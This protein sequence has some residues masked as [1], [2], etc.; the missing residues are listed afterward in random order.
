MTARAVWIG[1]LMLLP[2]QL[3]AQMTKPEVFGHIGVF[4]AGSDDGRIGSAA[5]FGGV[6]VIPVARRFAADV[7][8]QTARVER[9]RTADS[10]YITRRTL[11]VP[12]LLYRWGNDTAYGFFGGG[13][14][15][16]IRN[17]IYRHDTF[18]AD[19]TPIGWREIRPRVFELD[20]SRTETVVS[21]RGGFAVFPTER[22]GFRADLYIADWHIGW[23]IGFGYRFE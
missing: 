19:F 18:R 3:Q 13:I 2:F 14:G 1:L 16:E 21:L 10:F 20:R 23:R 11:I 17:S 6:L 15:A 22:F 5:S 7:D 4:R 9:V 12:Q 8:I